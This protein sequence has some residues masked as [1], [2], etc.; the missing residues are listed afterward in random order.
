MR[1]TRNLLA[2]RQDGLDVGQRDRGGTTFVALHHAAHHLSHHFLIFVVQRVPF[3]LSD[4]LYDHLFGRLSSN[5][6]DHFLMIQHLTV[7]NSM[8]TTVFTVD[9]EFDFGL[10]PVLLPG[11]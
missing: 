8:N 10:V 1:F 7:A 11:C 6:P 3:G 2:P 4:L 9:G 5:P